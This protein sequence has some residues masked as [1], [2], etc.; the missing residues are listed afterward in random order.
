MCGIV[1]I[2]HREATPDSGSLAAALDTLK[3]RGPDDS[4]MWQDAFPLSE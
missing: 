3:L 4:G 2:V 1:G